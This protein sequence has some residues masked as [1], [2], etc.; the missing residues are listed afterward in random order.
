MYY[1][2]HYI[3]NNK[4]THSHVPVGD[5]V[6]DGCSPSSFPDCTQRASLCSDSWL[7]YNVSHMAFPDPSLYFGVTSICVDPTNELQLVIKQ[8]PKDGRRVA[9]PT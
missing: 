2:P 4:Q 9:F 7:M 3:S 5:G 1:K 6:Q 8:A